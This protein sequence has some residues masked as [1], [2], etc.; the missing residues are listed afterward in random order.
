[1]QSVTAALTWEYLAR[2]RWMLLLAPLIEIAIVFTIMLPLI[3]VDVSGDS[4]REF[5]A[6]HMISVLCLVVVIGGCVILSQGSISSLYLKPLSTTAIVNYFYWGG[7]LLVVCQVVLM[8]WVSRILFVS[9]LPIIGSVLFAVVCWGVFQP[10]FRGPLNSLS[11]MIL[12]PAVFVVLVCWLMAKHGMTFQR[13]GAIS[14]QVHYWTTISGTD[15]LIAIATLG[16]SY[17]LTLWKVNFDRSGR[18]RR[19][20][21]D[22]I[23]EILAY[24]DARSVSR[25]RLFESSVQA[26]AWYDFAHRTVT[27]PKAVLCLIPWFLLLAIIAGTISQDLGVGLTFALIGVSAAAFIQT[28]PAFFVPFAHYLG[29]TVI[30]E[31]PTGEHTNIKNSLPLG[32]SPYLFS[33]PMSDKQRAHAILR[34]SAW[35]CGI[36]STVILL[37]FAVVAGLSWTLGADLFLSN[38]KV[39]P[40]LDAIVPWFLVVVWGGSSLLSFVFA[41]L[42]FTIDLRKW[43]LRDWITPA[44][45]IAVL[46]ASFTPIALSLSMGL[47]AIAGAYIV[48]STA[49][50]VLREDISWVGAS[51][52]WLAGTACAAVLFLGIPSEMRSQGL[53]LGGTLIFLAMLPFFT[54]VSAIR[55]LRTT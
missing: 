48:Y 7:A 9:D 13:G 6:I 25:I 29:Q 35:A 16:I 18:R 42:V 54:M 47:C 8:L 36:A 1:M 41:T 55:D 10:I 37:Y 21:T 5:I 4:P 3:G 11:W 44:I 15:G 30:Q 33:L 20:S 46:L 38:D 51:L 45:L 19:T 31:I 14:P 27:I 40:K 22:R 53:V 2:N 43:N 34:S 12:A 28:V 49:H 24:V 26:Q 17:V 39:A 32:M 23:A 52:V 50:A